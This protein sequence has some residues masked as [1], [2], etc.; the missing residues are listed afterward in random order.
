MIFKDI[1]IL[2]DLQKAYDSFIQ[3][4]A[5]E[6]ENRLFKKYKLLKRILRLLN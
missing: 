6:I 4:D 5:K 2:S 3:A 1:P